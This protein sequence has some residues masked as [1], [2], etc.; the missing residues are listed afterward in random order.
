MKNIYVHNEM[1]SI[2]NGLLT[3]TLKA[4]RPELKEFFKAKIDELYSSICMWMCS[5]PQFFFFFFPLSILTQKISFDQWPAAWQK[6]V[7][8]AWKSFE[9]KS[10]QCPNSGRFKM[11]TK[12]QVKEKTSVLQYTLSCILGHFLTEIIKII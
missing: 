7:S 1:F 9:N 3:P 11:A 8:W 4:K 6:C 5:R 12:R 10:Q 2:E